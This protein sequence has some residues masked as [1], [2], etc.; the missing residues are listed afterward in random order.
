MH[1]IRRCLVPPQHT[2]VQAFP[3]LRHKTHTPSAIMTIHW[4]V[5]LPFPN[6][7]C[8][9]L[10]SSTRAYRQCEKDISGQIVTMGRRHQSHEVVRP[11][12]GYFLFHW[13]IGQCNSLSVQTICTV[14]SITRPVIC[15]FRTMRIYYDELRYAS[16]DPTPLSPVITS[17]KPVPYWRS[18]LDEVRRMEGHRWAALRYY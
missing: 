2:L 16:M 7:K 18:V 11:Y 12:V 9:A 14:N 13:Q 17:Q 15:V 10:T 1:A 6:L 8:Q 3:R 4:R 5:L